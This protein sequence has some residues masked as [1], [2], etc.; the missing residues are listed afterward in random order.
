MALFIVDSLPV[1][2][3]FASA[4][5][6]AIGHDFETI[7][8]LSN[9]T[10]AYPIS[11]PPIRH[12]GVAIPSTSTVRQLTKE[13]ARVPLNPQTD[14]F[15]LIGLVTHDDGLTAEAALLHATGVDVSGLFRIPLSPSGTAPPTHRACVVQCPKALAEAALLLAAP[16]N[17]EGRRAWRGVAVGVDD[18]PGAPPIVVLGAGDP[19]P[20][21]DPSL[22][23]WSFP[24]V[25]A[26]AGL[27]QIP[28]P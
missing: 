22:V 9:W 2:A 26:A 6:A 17:P 24:A 14:T 16:G 10:Y 15:T 20:A 18:A 27:Q 11:A 7:V 19:E 25:L 12:S 5:H 23:R 28:Q 13:D 8:R 1:V 21:S 3:G 4:V